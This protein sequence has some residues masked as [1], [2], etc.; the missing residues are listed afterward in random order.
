MNRKELIYRIKEKKSF[1]CVGLDPDIDRI[2]S[3]EGDPVAR[4]LSF[5]KQVIDATRDYCVAYKPNTAFY[6]MYGAAGW[7]VLEETIAY[8]GPEHFVIA[9]AKRGDI[10][11]TSKKYAHAFFNTLKADA[12][13]V[14]PYMGIDS[15]APFLE[16]EGHWVVLLGLTSNVGSLDFQNQ[17]L[18]SGE[19]LFERVLRHS[20]NW[21]SPENMMYVVGATHPESF[22]DIRKILPEHFLLVPGIGSQGGDFDAVCR[23]GMNRDIGLLINVSRGILYPNNSEEAWLDAIIQSAKQYSQ[24]MSKWV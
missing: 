21:G 12:V 11:N 20:S 15:V 1:L 14:A 5:N 9:D 16:Y 10:G 7:Q 18:D 19:K 8:I 24:R 22:K 3:K 6:E 17:I 2:P 23:H 4:I 13:T